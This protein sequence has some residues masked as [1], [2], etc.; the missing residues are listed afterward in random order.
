MVNKYIKINCHWA[1]DAAPAP[2]FKKYT[3]DGRQVRRGQKLDAGGGEWEGRLPAV[4]SS[5]TDTERG[6]LPGQRV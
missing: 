2:P 1:K 6:V 5:I 3:L 4:G